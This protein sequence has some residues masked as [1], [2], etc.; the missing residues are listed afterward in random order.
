MESPG[1]AEARRYNFPATSA[2][3][4][5]HSKIYKLPL[6][7]VSKMA[8]DLAPNGHGRKGEVRNRSQVYNPKIERYV[9]RDANNGRF[10]DVKAD[11]KP[12][13]GVRKERQ[14]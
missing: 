13:K 11:P 2:V 12:F 1:I 14:G 7:G 10:I 9:K 6:K 5:A 3:I 8:K 4:L